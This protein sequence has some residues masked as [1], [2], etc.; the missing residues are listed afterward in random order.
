MLKL[1]DR[2][3]TL[4]FVFDCSNLQSLLVLASLTYLDRLVLAMESEKVCVD[5]SEII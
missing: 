4:H 3:H 1:L 5:I 2:L